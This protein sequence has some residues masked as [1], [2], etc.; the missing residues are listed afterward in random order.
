[1]GKKL[2][3]KFTTDC[4]VSYRSFSFRTLSPSWRSLET[5]HLINEM[6]RQNSSNFSAD[7]KLAPD[8]TGSRLSCSEVAHLDTFALGPKRMTSVKSI[9]NSEWVFFRASFRWRG[10]CTPHGDDIS[11]QL[12]D[13]RAASFVLPSAGKT[14]S[15]C[16]D[17]GGGGGC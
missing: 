9:M 5:V 7:A 6:T 4:A 17:G 1:M 12:E 8:L 11:S 15:H 3:C 16:D 2:N 14:C 10:R 13:E